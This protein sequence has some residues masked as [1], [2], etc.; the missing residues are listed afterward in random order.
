MLKFIAALLFAQ[1]L[2]AAPLSTLTKGTLSK[3]M[4]EIDESAWVEYADTVENQAKTRQPK[5][6]ELASDCR[7]G[8]CGPLATYTNV[9]CDA[10]G[11]NCKLL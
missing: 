4:P 1:V 6:V 7:L 8:N 3:R 11:E 5:Q 10:H 2:V 9:H